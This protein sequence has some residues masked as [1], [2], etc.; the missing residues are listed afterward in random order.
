MPTS[1]RHEGAGPS[2][3]F[4]VGLL[5]LAGL[6]LA[7]CL[8][9]GESLVSD[10]LER[11]RAIRDFGV[12]SATPERAV[13]A[14]RGKRVVI[15]PAPGSC[16]ARDSIEVSRTLAF[17]VVSDCV[18]ERTEP[19]APQSAEAIEIE[20]PA[21]FPGVITVSVSGAPMDEDAGRG[22]PAAEDLRAFLQTPE[23]RAQLGR[24]GD[25]AAVEIAESRIVGETLYVL[26]SDRGAG[27]S[28][29][30]APEFWRAFAEVND[31]MVLATVS[32][33]RDRPMSS[34]TMLRKLASQVSALRAANGMERG[35]AVAGELPAAVPPERVNDRATK[36]APYLAPGVRPAPRAPTVARA[37]AAPGG[38]L[39]AK[40]TTGGGGGAPGAAAGDHAPAQAPRARARPSV[41]A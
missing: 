5:G 6:G 8:Q 29:L 23:G 4:R 27:A 37:S 20:L 28:P 39:P 13:L 10:E 15:E 7:G 26:I 1:D 34:E 11:V 14:A 2:R 12:I 31:R 40:I 21:A 38:P 22:R 16:I 36:I 35:E 33:F 17:L 18:I 25:A 19:L 24:G 32:G 41:R 9:T 3:A 30:L